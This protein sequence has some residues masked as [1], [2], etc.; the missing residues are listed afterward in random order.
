MEMYEPVLSDERRAPEKSPLTKTPK[1][2]GSSKPSSVAASLELPSDSGSTTTSDTEEGEDKLSP[3]KKITKKERKF[4]TKFQNVVGS[5]SPSFFNKKDKEELLSSS[6][7]SSSS[8][9]AS[10]AVSPKNSKIPVPPKKGRKVNEEIGNNSSTTNSSTQLLDKLVIIPVEVPQPNLLIFSDSDVE[11]NQPKDIIVPPIANEESLVQKIEN[12]RTSHLIPIPSHIIELN[13]QDDEQDKKLQ[14]ER[15]KVSGHRRVMSEYGVDDRSSSDKEGS[16]LYI[17]GSDGFTTKTTT[18]YKENKTLQKVNAELQGKVLQQEET[19]E[20]LRKTTEQLIKE[21][22]TLQLLT[23]D[24]KNQILLQLFAKI[25]S[26]ESM[27][28]EEREG[29][30]KGQKKFVQKLAQ[31]ERVVA[32]K[33]AREAEDRHKEQEKKKSQLARDRA[34]SLQPR[35]CEKCGHKFTILGNTENSCIYHPGKWKKWKKI[36]KCCGQG[37]ESLGCTSQGPHVEKPQEKTS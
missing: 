18:V 28:T 1:S 32:E 7:S 36:Y 22:Q 33:V 27:L 8:S 34:N 21:N 20:N 24:D 5:K 37:R 14:R 35:T 4:Q 2:K 16:N 15:A 12:L 29:R 9:H 23:S 30:K 11:R 19:Y 13:P 25:D 31:L 10:T 6:S 17:D 3:S 26:L